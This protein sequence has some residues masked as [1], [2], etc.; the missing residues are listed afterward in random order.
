[1]DSVPDSAAVNE[2]VKLAR[3]RGFANLSG[4]VNGVLRQ[5]ERNKD[6]VKYPDKEKTPDEYLSVK[7]SMPAWIVRAVYKS[8]LE[9]KRLRL[10]L[11]LP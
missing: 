4:F 1:M 5:I 8:G 11:P 10:F 6:N 7:Y 3:K 2:S 9:V